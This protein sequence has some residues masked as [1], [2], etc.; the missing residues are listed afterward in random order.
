MRLNLFIKVYNLLDRL[1]ELKV[2]DSTGRATYSL[3]PE[4]YIND[5]VFHKDYITRPNYFDDPRLVLTG[6]AIE[7]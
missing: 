7:F 2:W 3:N 6:F 4:P 5:P 1:N